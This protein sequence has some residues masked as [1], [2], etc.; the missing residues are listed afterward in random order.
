MTKTCP[1]QES[2]P[3]DVVEWMNICPSPK[4]RSKMLPW[5][6]PP[7]MAPLMEAKN[8]TANQTKSCCPTWMPWA[9]ANRKS[10]SWKTLLI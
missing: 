2:T 6:M 5:Q 3:D 7:V 9:Q 8:K 4:T 1:W 10:S